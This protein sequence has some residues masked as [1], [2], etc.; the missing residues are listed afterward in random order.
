MEG[1][2]KVIVAKAE[3]AAQVAATNAVSDRLERIS[4]RF[5]RIEARLPPAPSAR[6]Q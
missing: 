6:D 2:E 4:E 3:A 1:L 5:A